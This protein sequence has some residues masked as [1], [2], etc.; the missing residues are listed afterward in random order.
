MTSSTGAAPTTTLNNTM[1]KEYTLPAECIADRGRV[2]TTSKKDFD[3][4][5]LEVSDDD[6]ATWD[7]VLTNR[8]DTDVS[9]GPEPRLQRR[10]GP[11]HGRSSGGVRASSPPTYSAWD[12]RR[13]S[14]ASATRRTADLNAPWLLRREH[15]GHRKR[16]RRCGGRAVGL[17]VRRLQARPAAPR[18]RSTSTRNRP[19][20]AAYR[21]YDESLQ[22]DVQLRL[23]RTRGR[24]GS[25][26][27]RTRTGC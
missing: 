14:S 18:R 1:T 15:R 20:T 17:G 5:F 9:T 7:P 21:G 23:P 8:S 13:G 11:G 27:I 16:R 10:P 2:P 3:Y 22:F 12:G 6:G 24:T 19:R 26:P 4:A 25:R